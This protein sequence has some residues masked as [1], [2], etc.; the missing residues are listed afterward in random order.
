VPHERGKEL[1][2]EL[3]SKSGLYQKKALLREAQRYTVNV[4]PWMLEQLCR[5]NAIAL[6]SETGLLC[7]NEGWYSDVLGVCIEHV[8]E[9]SVPIA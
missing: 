3:A 6:L 9:M 2:A 8:G 7:L 4:H 5:K 1:I